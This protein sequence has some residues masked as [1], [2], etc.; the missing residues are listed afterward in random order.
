MPHK[1]GQHS[2]RERDGAAVKQTFVHLRVRSVY[3]P[4]EGAIRL[5][6]LAELCAQR[7]MPAVGIADS[8]NLFGALEF[9]VTAAGAGI[10][11]VIGCAVGLDHQPRAGAR[12][13]NRDSRHPEIALLAQ[14][15]EGYRNLLHLVSGLHLESADGALELDS[16]RARNA[17]LICLTGGPWGPLGELLRAGQGVA[18]R[19][20]LRS[21]GEMFDSRL[22]VEIQRNHGEAGMTETEATV[23]HEMLACAFDGGYPLVATNDACFPD[24][25]FFEAHQV[26]LSIGP[27][28]GRGSEAVP[29]F[30]EENYFKTAEEMQ[31]R[32]ADL[33]EALE[34]TLDI[35]RRCSFRPERS[36]PQLPRF[37]ENEVA[38]LREDAASGL[39]AR[40][41]EIEPATEASVYRERIE[42]EL[43]VIEGMQ[44]AGYFLI[45]ADFVNWARGN[46]IP[47]GPGRGSGAGSLVAYALRITDLDPIR[48]GLLFERFLNPERVSMPDFDID[49]CEDR[50]DEVLR[51][52]RD[53]Y[54][55]ERV[56]KIITFG[57]LQARAAV[58]DVARSLG[59]SYRQADS[60][61]K[62]IPANP[63]HPVTLGQA[64]ETV[65]E[66]RQAID[67]EPSLRQMYDIAVRL[68]GLY[69]NVSVHAAGI[70]IGDRP[71]REYIPLYRDPRS[72][73]PISGFTMGWAEAAGLVKFDLLG[74]KT[75]TA[76]AEAVA[77]LG[78]REIE[79]D[80]ATIPLTDKKTFEL[81]GSAETMG[82]FQVEGEGMREALRQ[83]APDRFE[84]IIALVALYRPGPMENI[85]K[86]CAVKSGKADIER[87]HPK[88]D[89]VLRETYGIVVYQE[90]VMEIA[91]TLAGFELGQADILRRAMGKKLPEE[92][93][94]QRV[95]FVDGA[96]R[97][98]DMSQQDAGRMFD[99]VSR[100]ADYGF[101]KSHAA[102]YA[103]VSY[104]TAY[105][106]ANHPAEF[107]AAIMN[108]ELSGAATEGK[109]EAYRSDAL[110][111]RI[112]MPPP[113]VNSS[114]AR[115][116]PTGDAI[117]YAL[118]ALKGVGV[119]AASV[120]EEERRARGA[121]TSV[122]DFARRVELRRV[123]KSALESMVRAGAFDELSANRR[124]MLEAVPVLIK[125][126]ED[127]RAGQAEGESGLLMGGEEWDIP[128][129]QLPA[130][131]DLSTEE[132]FEEERK[133]VGFLISGHPLEGY[134]ETLR[135]HRIGYCSRL[136]G[137]ELNG[138]EHYAA[139]LIGTVD[140][141]RSKRGNSY[142][143]V[144]VS[145]PEGTATIMVFEETLRNC[146]KLLTPGK[147]VLMT[148]TLDE[149]R[150]GTSLVCRGLQPLEA[151]G[152]GRR[153]SPPPAAIRVAVGSAE[154]AGGVERMLRGACGQ[155]N[156]RGGT[157]V[158][159]LLDIR[160]ERCRV[161]F[162]L[163]G[164]FAVTPELQEGIGALPGVVS[165]ESVATEGVT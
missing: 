136:Q 110:R 74:L 3:S 139:G 92:M 90:Q 75:L 33:P 94:A 128:D 38:K 111:L 150:R 148:L 56:A 122:G 69:R 144:S 107:L 34:N 140:L 98:S 6:A 18:A 5:K 102:A 117:P 59:I 14:N 158:E 137:E 93:A 160:D 86:F 131:E 23:E 103:L 141:R 54:G 72:D 24:R 83:L 114:G 44:Y 7:E 115:F 63:A 87:L 28:A 11:P 9:S 99:L 61:A 46:G 82:V 81:Y 106:K 49:F 118:G 161:A 57:S 156:G 43:G 159:L 149:G 17:G 77:F 97:V 53:R 154:A 80:I 51:H 13:R 163:V 35:A 91:R 65:P 22:Y 25:D 142:A 55:E 19:E 164:A 125:Y 64:Y 104:Q 112:K 138:G 96:K 143:R 12:P 67:A 26:F 151:L 134:A 121:F 71:L 10:Q 85:P 66:F 37:A 132:R 58:R 52:V 48:Y 108:T 147:A 39:E 21:L 135:R 27:Q 1:G 89:P 113:A 119:S 105:L 127:Y 32:F 70:V 100:F 40:L 145:D 101:N 123:G 152:A 124:S 2:R 47:V 45:V 8:G 78:E 120:I 42:Y 162:E 155:S 41:R 60:V 76:I 30:T 109:L 31:Q 79:V 130:V 153:A 73:L 62:L 126:S 68:E 95:T 29:R 16:L 129:P 116:R 20:L 36:S 50:R 157:R 4:L 88:V 146:R 15:E 84:D 133:A 165:V